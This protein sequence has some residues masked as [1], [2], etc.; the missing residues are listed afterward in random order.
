MEH[1]SAKQMPI[2][3]LVDILAG[4]L[5]RPVIDLTGIRGV[6]DVTLDW[7]PEN[8]PAAAVETK[9]P[10]SMALEDQ[11]GLKLEARKTRVDVIVVDH[12]ERSSEN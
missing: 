1:L 12:A 10:L 7:T 4:Q 2:S 11:L 3:Q 6:F 5:D 9:P 8:A